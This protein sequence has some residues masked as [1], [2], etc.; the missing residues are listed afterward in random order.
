[1]TGTIAIISVIGV[2]IA[3]LTNVTS[4]LRFL[5]DRRERRRKALAA[6][7]GN[8]H[9]PSATPGVL[10]GAEAAAW[11]A[12]TSY[13]T[14]PPIAMAGVPRP[15]T[16]FVG[17]QLSLEEV[18]RLLR[19][20]D[21]RL[22][23][24]YGPGGIGKSRL[25]MRAA[26]ELGDVFP[27]G[28]A[29]V[30][31]DTVRESNLVLSEVALVLGLRET[32]GAGPLEMIV[33]ALRGQKLLLVL[34]NF[35]ELVDAAPQLTAL[36]SRLPE[37]K[38]LV[39]SRVILRARGEVTYAVPPL[40][41]PEQG[42][43]LSLEEVTEYASVRL[44]KE[45]AQAVSPDFQLTHENL[46]EVVEICRRLDG[47]PLAIELA[48]ARLRSMSIGTLRDRITRSLPLLTGGP[49]DAPERQRTL[50]DTIALSF[51]L[52]EESP[53]RLFTRLGVFSGSLH[54][55]AAEQVLEGST[56]VDDLT[57]LCDASMLTRV[58]GDLE[59]FTMLE[60]L[61]EFAVEKL[62]ESGEQ[63]ELAQRHANYFLDLATRAFEGLRVA[64][65]ERW[66]E[67]LR[68]DEANLRNAINTFIETGRVDDAL[69]LTTSLRPYWQRS[70]SLEEGR[71]RLQH[72][73][74][75]SKEAPPAL[76]GPALLAEGILAW[77]QGDLTAARPLL[78]ESLELARAEGDRW[79]LVSAMR[80]LGV[81]AQNQ[82]DYARAESLLTESVALAKQLGDQELVGNAYLSL[83]N[84]ALDQSHHD[85]AVRFYRLS[86]EIAE[87]MSDTL[88]KAHALDNLSVTAWHRGDLVEAKRLADEV[89]ELYDEL[90][91][92]SGK[93][94]VW[95]RYCLIALAK[96]NLAEAEREGLRALEVRRLHGEGRGAAFVLFDLARISL[97]GRDPERARERLAEGLELAQVHGSPVISVLYVEATAALLRRSQQF[98]DAYLL[99][100]GSEAWRERMGV[101]IAAVNVQAYQR[102]R[103]EIAGRLNATSRAD[104]E[105]RAR[106]MTEDQLVAV[107]AAHLADPAG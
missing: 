83:G 78:E 37:L 50:R 51:D 30:A 16:S 95:H 87:R 103:R 93:A 18:G 89:Y 86:L 70:G 52:L 77:R 54:L 96:G 94:N 12:L 42:Q 67:R 32:T 47:L 56:L 46:D 99:L 9:P 101:P 76:R 49:R 61:R 4:I 27:D 36:L 13:D 33:A 14:P 53:Q 105:R 75:L 38:I 22:L 90:K 79:S 84:V 88:G 15:L 19:R 17:R 48:A 2:V 26:A 100:A 98:E 6:A 11:P 1:M 104:I 81:L 55:E 40:R 80:T 29:F 106:D 97:L 59:R 60:T 91:M 8:A 57:A 82:A 71:R 65:Q 21:V 85:E 20:P 92:T 25:A 39:T 45:R 31:L 24:L 64:G 62:S 102:M 3:I 5:D 41:L 107:T 23:T 73:L 28:V 44:F 63:A 43:P 34:D 66:L 7:D 69:R 10:Q 58:S 35:E 72:V 74:S 68:F